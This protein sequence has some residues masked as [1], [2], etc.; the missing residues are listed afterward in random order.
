MCPNHKYNPPPT[1]HWWQRR[2]KTIWKKMN[3]VL[4]AILKTFLWK[5][6]FFGSFEDYFIIEIQSK[7]RNLMSTTIENLWCIP[8]QRKEKSERTNERKKTLSG[9]CFVESMSSLPS[10]HME[11]IY[12]I[13]CCCSLISFH[14][15][16]RLMGN[17]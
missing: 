9:N 13:F 1:C 17:V 7:F 4:K 2:F 14:V 16:M 10:K 12:S 5:S 8:V 3:N 15:I 11:K 6:F